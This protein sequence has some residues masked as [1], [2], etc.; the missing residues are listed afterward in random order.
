MQYTIF[1]SGPT[2]CLLPPT[3]QFFYMPKN[4][5][6]GFDPLTA[7][8]PVEVVQDAM[9]RTLKAVGHTLC[10]TSMP[11]IIDLLLIHTK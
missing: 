10:A 7:N 8:L 2:H 4:H 11:L 1:I 6:T 9:G 3:Q 5:L